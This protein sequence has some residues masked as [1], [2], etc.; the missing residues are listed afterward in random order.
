MH[1]T[2]MNRGD[3]AST[4]SVAQTPLRKLW[5]L[6]VSTLSRH[7]HYYIP[8]HMLTTRQ[9]SRFLQACGLTWQRAQGLQDAHLAHSAAEHLAQP[10][11][12]RNQV[13]W[14]GQY[15]PHW[16]AEALHARPDVGCAGLQGATS[17]FDAPCSVV[18]QTVKR[19]YC[20]IRVLALCHISVV[21]PRSSTKSRLQR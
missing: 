20:Q 15:R 8:D 1:A 3:W 2:Y 10:P 5:R 18:L 21:Q 9:W 13:C 16:R 6:A 4:C 17:A 19:S 12:S 7:N 14:P 11:P